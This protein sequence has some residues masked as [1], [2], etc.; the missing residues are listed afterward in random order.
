VKILEK[1]VK[2]VKTSLEQ[3]R[4]FGQFSFGEDYESFKEF[5]G[6]YFSTRAEHTIYWLE[7]L[8]K[9]IKQEEI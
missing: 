1:K 6:D 7:E 2:S 4:H 3:I 9:R 5:M 8:I